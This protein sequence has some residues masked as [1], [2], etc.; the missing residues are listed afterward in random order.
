MRFRIG[1]ILPIRRKSFENRK[2]RIKVFS[3]IEETTLSS[4]PSKALIMIIPTVGCSWALS[5]SGGC[6]MCGYINDSTLD[7][8]TDAKFY[9]I[10]EWMKYKDRIHEIEAVKLYNSGSFLDP[11]E[12]PVESQKQIVA[13][14]SEYS[15]IKELVIE[16][17]P[18]IVNMQLEVLKSLVEIFK[19][20]KIFIGLGL[21]SSNDYIN[22]SY[23]NKSFYFKQFVK[24]VEN[25]FKVGA[26]PKAYLLLKGP[27]LT[28]RE[29]IQDA[30]QSIK[31]AFSTGCKIVSINP[32]AVHADTLINELFEKKEYVPPWLWSVLEVLK[33]AHPNVPTD[34]LLIC[35]IMAGGKLRGAHNCG[36]CDSSVIKEIQYY[37]LHNKFSP[38]VNKLNCK[39]KREWKFILDNEA[40]LSRTPP[41]FNRPMSFS[42]KQ[43]L[44]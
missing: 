7:P 20:R 32:V 22:R 27:F 10:K 1:E 4:G 31:D 25:T 44:N 5:K 29:S 19:G 34:G 9:F 41:I 26:F 40:L 6:S 39:C 28:E 15:N 13:K 18:E 36:S 37:S 16:C 38:R 17:L 8:D 2:R 11:S 35:E 33:Q 43:V 42:E 3:K 14:I 12:I 30:V 23:V 21:E 24:C